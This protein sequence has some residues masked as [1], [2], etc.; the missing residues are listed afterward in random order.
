M[1]NQTLLIPLSEIQIIVHLP[2]LQKVPSDAKGF[3]GMLNYHGESVPVYGLDA[4]IQGNSRRDISDYH[5]DT[6]LI[7]C[8]ISDNKVGVLVDAVDEVLRIDTDTIQNP[9]LSQLPHFVAG[10]FE[11]ETGSMWVMDLDVLLLP[12]EEGVT[13]ASH[14]S[15]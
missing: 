14:D 2:E 11:T 3:R 10:I 6:P 5:I 15:G 13:G 4:W 9:K 7:I 12:H 8:N 1:L